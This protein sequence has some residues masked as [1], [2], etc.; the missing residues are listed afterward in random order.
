MLIFRRGGEH[1]LLTVPLA[2]V[3]KVELR[4]G[5]TIQLQHGRAQSPQ[6]LVLELDTTDECH[7][8]VACVRAS[9]KYQLAKAGAPASAVSQS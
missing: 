9:K 3:Q 4:K 7:V 6:S 8:F 5:R 2:G 1:V